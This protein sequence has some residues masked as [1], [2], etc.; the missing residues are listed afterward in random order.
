[1]KNPRSHEGSDETSQEHTRDSSRR[2]E[3]LEVVS[4]R[5]SHPFEDN[6]P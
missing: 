6:R 1:M 3:Y 5:S 4:R 2:T